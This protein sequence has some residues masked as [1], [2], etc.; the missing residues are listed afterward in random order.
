MKAQ[1]KEWEP[2]K[3]WQAWVEKRHHVPPLMAIGILL[4]VSLLL[5]YLVFWISPQK[6]NVLSSLILWSGG[7]TILVNLLPL[8]LL[9]TLLYFC[10]A[11]LAASIA[12]VAF[13]A[14]LMAVVNRIKQSL[15]GDPLVHWDLPLV[16]EAVNVVRGFGFWPLALGITAA[17]VFLLLTVFAATH[18]RIEK[19][20]ARTRII[21]ALATAA[22]ITVLNFTLY[23][24]P[25]VA[26][27]LPV[28]GS[29]YNSTDV[30]NSRGNIYAF[31]YDWNTSRTRTPDG[32]DEDRA[33]AFISAYAEETPAETASARPH[34]IM[35]MGEAFSDLS[36]SA[37]CDFTGYTDPLAH[38]K[39][40][41]SEGIGGSIVV[42]AR[43]G[44]TAD[45]EFD[46]LTA[47][48]TRL[49]RGVP[50]Q[51]RTIIRSIEAMPSLLA[52]AGYDAFA[53]HPG[54]GWF[55]NRQNV[56]QLLG[57][58][59]IVFEDAFDRDTYM[60]TFIREDATYD[61]LLEMIQSRLDTSPDTPM[62]GFC[63]TIQ[64]H[65]PYADRFVPSG[66][67]TFTPTVP[68]T[69]G[70]VTVLSNYF[71]GVTDADAQ[72]SRLTDLLN[73]QDTPC[74]VVYFG[75]HLP[76]L[77]EALYDK[78]IPGA[79]AAEGSYEYE[80][81]LYRTPFV[82]WPNAAA[83][84]QNLLK[85]IALPK[86][87]TISSQFLGAYMMELLG[88]ENLS[89]YWRFVGEVRAQYPVITELAAYTPDGTPAN[90]DDDTLLRAYYDWTTIRLLRD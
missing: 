55:Y 59:E 80:T 30:H 36:E 19:L 63:L 70:E 40:L 68:M 22:V 90:A 62:F 85:D 28:W 2:R 24:S 54:Y 67:A 65:A 89:P 9:M 38:F 57:F 84:E 60:D 69:E 44:G 88:L 27:A 45:T 81:R 3:V 50:Y 75:D 43:G 23:A 20:C 37:A 56:Y 13:V 48:P 6:M 77:D 15:R 72:L 41:T 52:G 31:L 8:F 16:K 66:T 35:I 49:N 83:R 39:S 46:V 79:E 21:G 76:A 33:D 74:I 18:F 1:R 82:I 42:S 10:T 51:Y 26:K 25:A 17:I 14:V 11:N 87:G 4:V 34:I 71:A 12:P 61:M 64:N 7:L 53:M 86:N 29:F 47:R 32:F 73:A 5:T 78:L 58:D